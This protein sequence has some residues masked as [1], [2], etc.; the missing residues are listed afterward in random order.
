MDNNHPIKESS[1]SE[2]TEFRA[3]KDEF[4]ATDHH[5]PLTHDQQQVFEGLEYFPENPDLRLEL[6]V[7]EFAEKESIEM[8]TST[9]DI[10]T[11]LRYG[12]I[13]FRVDHQEVELTLYKDAHGFFLPFVDDQAGKETYG[14]GRYLEPESLP[15]G[16]LLV[17]F[18][19]AYNPYCAYNDLYSCPLTPWENHLK[20]PIMAG[21]K[22]PTGKWANHDAFQTK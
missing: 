9:G 6:E 10:Q 15:D 1:M 18:N 8:Q 12:K 2:L 13:H 19:Y 11:H 5:S 7:E 17:D 21:E 3:S 4:F 14:A 16:K 22:L 20:V